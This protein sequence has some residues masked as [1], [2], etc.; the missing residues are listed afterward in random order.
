MSSSDIDVDDE[1][2]VVDRPGGPAEPVTPTTAQTPDADPAGFAT[3]RAANRDLSSHAGTDSTAQKWLNAQCGMISGVIRAVVCSTGDDTSRDAQ[4]GLLAQ[5][6]LDATGMPPK[7]VETGQS[8][9]QKQ[10]VVIQPGDADAAAPLCIVAAPLLSSDHEQLAVALELPDAVRRQ[11]QA[12]VQILRWGAT[13]FSLLWKGRHTRSGTDRLADIVE[14]LASSLGRPEFDATATIAVTELAAR[15]NCNRV[16]LGLMQRRHVEVCAISNSARFDAR[17]NLVRNIAAAMD[18]AVD[19]NASVVFPPLPDGRPHVSFAQEVLARSR[20]GRAVC[21]TP[22]YDGSRPAGALTLERDNGEAFDRSTIEACEVFGA[23]L[24]PVLQLKFERERWIGSRIIEDLRKFFARLCGGKDVALK[25]YTLAAVALIFFFSFATTDY[26]VT[27]QATLEGSVRRVITAPRDGFVA[28]ANLRAGDLVAA[29]QV[30]ATLDDR[31]LRLERLKLDSQR[32]QLDKEYRAALASH[33]RSGAAIV[34]A[35][36][37]QVIAQIALADEQLERT[38]LTAPF[39]GIVVAGDLSQSLGSPVEHGQVLFEVAPLD[40]YR[41]ILQV[42]ERDIGEVANQQ[43]GK[44]TLTGLPDIALPFTVTQ[45]VPISTARDGR[46]FFEVEAVLDGEQPRIRPGM[47]GIGKIHVDQRK[48][49]WVWT[50]ELID[51]LRLLLW[52]WLK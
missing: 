46:N 21:S 20:D 28:S 6:P 5:W 31:E 38:R 29:G 50:H 30:L 13:W 36:L 41:V 27:A 3:P 33:D 18:E 26:R 39:A 24:G 10:S 37:E 1:V 23:L 7:L 9:A 35:K 40:S 45:I 32:A 2:L 42:D 22:L 15:L 52:K 19:Q 17:S 51:W 16:S 49:L 44:L 34:S 8:A 4:P 14:M 11:Q 12:L 25:L 43:H 47:E 48:L